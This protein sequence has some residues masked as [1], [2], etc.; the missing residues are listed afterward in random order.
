MTNKY[1]IKFVKFKTEKMLRSMF[2]SF[3]DHETILDTEKR[4]LTAK[5]EREHTKLVLRFLHFVDM[6]EDSIA[7]CLL[8]I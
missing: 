5:E 1:R 2:I 4:I 3:A 6:Q 7:S 8:Q